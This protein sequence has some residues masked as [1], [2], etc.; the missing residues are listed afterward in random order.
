MEALLMGEGLAAAVI[1]RVT[2]ILTLAILACIAMRRSSAAMRHCALAAAATASLAAPFLAAFGPTWAL[3]SVGLMKADEP[4]DP[5]SPLP[6]FEFTHEPEVVPGSGRELMAASPRP[7]IATPVAAS[8]APWTWSQRVLAIWAVGAVVAAVPALVVGIRLRR[9]ANASQPLVEGRWDAMVDDLRSRLGG[10]RCVRLLQS[11]AVAS[12]MTWGV[13]RP[14]IVLP[15]GAETWPEG[16]LQAVLMHELAHVA[17]RDALAQVPARLACVVY[18]FHP[19]A[20]WTASRMLVERER[21]C[22]DLVLAAGWRG[23]DYAQRLLEVAQGLCGRSGFAGVAT[24]TRTSQVEDRVRAILDASRNH[25]P[26]GRRGILALAAAT[27]ALAVPLSSARLVAQAPQA[28]AAAPEAARMTISGRVLDPEGKPLARAKVAVVGHRQRAHESAWLEQAAIV[29][30]EGEADGTGRFRIETPRTSSGRYQN[31]NVVAGSPGFGLGWSA[32]NLDDAAP[33]VDVSLQPEQPVELR[34]LTPEGQPAAGLA[35]RTLSL[36]RELP[37]PARPDPAVRNLVGVNMSPQVPP[38]LAGLWRG[39]WNTDDEGRI[40]L[41]GLGRGVWAS[42][43]LDD[44]RYFLDLAFAKADAPE[45]T[46]RIE[47]K[48]K[49]SLRISG[50]ITGGDDGQPI[51]DA[52]VHLITRVNA[53]GAAR[54]GT[55]RTDAQGPYEVSLPPKSSNLEITISPPPGSPYLTRHEEFPKVPDAMSQTFDLMI[56]RGVLIE[57]RVRDRDD[58]PIADATVCYTPDVD[59]PTSGPSNLSGRTA[60][61]SSGNDGRFIIAVAPGKGTLSVNAATQDYALKEAVGAYHVRDHAHAFLAYDVHAGQAP[62]TV[63]AILDPGSKIVGRVED[64]EG[65]PVDHAEIITAASFAHSRFTWGGTYTIP[66]RDGRF[67][68]PGVTAGRPTKC[69][70]FDAEHGLGT[71]VEL[72]PAQ[73]AGGPITV[74]LQPSGEARMRVVD[75]QGQPYS[76]SAP[77]LSIVAEPGPPRLHLARGIPLTEEESKQPL[78]LETPY[79][80]FDRRNYGRT[81]VKKPDADGR[82]SFPQLIPGATYR[83]YEP[84]LNGGVETLRWRDF[85]V[86]PGQTIDL[87][88]VRIKPGSGG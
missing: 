49:S 47:V 80:L 64:P 76:A 6:V 16:R 69:W 82:A 59:E 24:M 60:G 1:A 74:K 56:P 26:L 9:L 44:P 18:W 3:P 22:D 83:I 13:F 63:N 77:L 87:G 37:P 29:L 10:V 50:R 4:V 81:V 58:R 72:D 23:V 20:W 32:F 12:P 78:A 33:T 35:V 65:R 17:R 40:H 28:P 31:A 73:A 14:V 5:S 34:F 66:V 11:D 88:D 85:T 52:I 2:I 8:A 53:A 38:V 45:G 61:V 48:L 39:E 86:A 55:A 57:G 19:L 42:L 54:G 7:T 30:G 15:T 84:T 62:V 68:I 79:I 67:E 21:A 51:P 70:F 46:K 25:R 71:V 41:T 43:N 75:I 27:T 36:T